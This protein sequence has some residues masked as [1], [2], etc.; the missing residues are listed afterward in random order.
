MTVETKLVIWDAPKN[1]KAYH[2]TRIGGFSKKHCQFSNMS[3]DVG[4]LQNYV[5]KNRNDIKNSLQ[6][7]SEPSW[8]KQIHGTT[9]KKITKPLKNIVCD[10]SYTTSQAIVCAVLSADC[11]PILVCN[12]AGTF[13]GVIHVGWRG[14]ENGII[15][16]FISKF[17]QPKNLLC[18]IGP[19]ISSKHYLVREDVYRKLQS[20]SPDI[21]RQVDK[22]HWSLDLA[23]AAKII[24]KAQ[25]VNKIFVD[26]MCTFEN[27]N[28]YYSY[29]RQSNTGRIASLIWIE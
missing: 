11:L 3:N 4:D 1:I 24:L 10:G 15:K 7:P 17:T 12:N 26:K 16:K 27:S 28:L 9:I 18:W 23:K 5:K 20:L 29:R 2:T 22:E 19:S 14:L 8:M 13:A 6:L 21:F 25:G